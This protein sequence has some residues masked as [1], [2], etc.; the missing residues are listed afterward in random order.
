MKNEDS[1]LVDSYYDEEEKSNFQFGGTDWFRGM[2]QITGVLQN[3]IFMF[4]K[5][6]EEITEEVLFKQN[7]TEDIKLDL[8]KVILLDNCSTMYLL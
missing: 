8:R 6:F 1:D 2:H 5:T 4:N 3:K 7:H